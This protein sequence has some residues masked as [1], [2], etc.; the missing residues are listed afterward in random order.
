MSSS[1]PVNS[2]PASQ[3]Y[4]KAIAEDRPLLET[5]HRG[6][7]MMAVV[8]V[9]LVQ[10]F[11][12]TIANVALPFMKSSLGAS[13]ETVSWVLTSF[14]MATAIATP[15]T[16]WLSDYIGSRNLFMYS[17]LLF[18]VSSAACGAAPPSPRAP[19]AA[20][21]RCAPAPAPAPAATLT[22][23]GRSPSARGAPR[24]RA[25]SR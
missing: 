6:L 25:A 14:I 2:S 24:N 17:T 1:T 5:R 8:L 13:T 20:R 9:S 23:A 3:A 15:L 4:A 22:T 10:F 21:R 19:A 16:G 18:L 12:A 11:D 7:L